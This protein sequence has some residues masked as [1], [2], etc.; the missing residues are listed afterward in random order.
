LFPQSIN[1]LRLTDIKF[2]YSE[3][4]TKVI[5]GLYQNNQQIVTYLFE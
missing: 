1:G 5:Y 2:G 3:Q 4:N